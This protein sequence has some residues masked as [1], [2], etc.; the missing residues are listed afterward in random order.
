MKAKFLSI[1]AIILLSSTSIFAQD[2]VTYSNVNETA[3]GSVKEYI[4][5]D[6]SSSTPLRKN[7]Y[8]EDINGQKISKATYKWI[9]NNWSGIQKVNYKFNADNQTTVLVYSKWDTKASD[10]SD[11]NEFFSYRY[12]DNGEL[13]TSVRVSISNSNNLMTVAQ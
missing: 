1:I 8:I 3:Q 10:W 12:N 9:D 11:K 5:Y 4:V 7:V 2:V 6:K 13:L